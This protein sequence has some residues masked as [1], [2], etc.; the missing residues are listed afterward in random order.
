MS[1]EVL[2]FSLVFKAGANPCLKDKSG[3]TSLHWAAHHGYVKC[4]KVLMNSKTSAGLTETD[5]VREY[6]CFA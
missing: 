5:H 3:R 6:F 1:F 2:S 4:L